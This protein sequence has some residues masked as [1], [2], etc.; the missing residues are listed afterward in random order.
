[1]FKHNAETLG[2]GVGIKEYMFPD[3]N[4]IL[5]GNG[6][7]CLAST[8][9]LWGNAL[10]NILED[11]KS[12]LSGTNT[13][14]FD[15]IVLNNKYKGSLKNC[16]YNGIVSRTE[17][18][19]E[20]KKQLCMYL[21]EK[22]EKPEFAEKTQPYFERLLNFKVKHYMC[23]N[24]DSVLMDVCGYFPKEKETPSNDSN[25]YRRI[26]FTRGE[27]TKTLWPIHG[28]N[29]DGD[30]QSVVLGYSQYCKYVKEII[31]Y[32]EGF[33]P[34]DN[35]QVSSDNNEKMARKIIVNDR[36]INSWV[37]FFFFTNVH[38]V[39]FGMDFA[40]LDLWEILNRR[41][42]YICEGVGINN[43]IYFYGT[44]NQNVNAALEAYDVIV[45]KPNVTKPRGGKIP[46]KYWSD[47]MDENIKN[48]KNN[49]ENGY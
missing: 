22:Y 8:D 39:G 12:C 5:L 49:I 14:A 19:N 10:N 17:K 7:H 15:D 20:A 2:G 43:K 31:D 1:M 40:E 48:L 3:E 23:T 44:P 24:Y 32:V 26:D 33:H 16:E 9:F 29:N 13:L 36:Y 25:K 42:M 46:K 45:V 38:I 27:N 11:G 28:H 18:F 6:I 21:Q 37:D 47:C 35:S 4:T 41:K 30:F 34:N